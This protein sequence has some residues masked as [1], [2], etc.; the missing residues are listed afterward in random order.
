MLPVSA[1]QA[2]GAFFTKQDVSPTPPLPSRP[3]SGDK[4]QMFRAPRAALGLWRP[5]EIYL[6]FTRL[7]SDLKGIQQL[8]MIDACENPSPLADDRHDN[9]RAVTTSTTTALAPAAERGALATEGGWRL[10]VATSFAAIAVSAAVAVAV[11]TARTT[12]RNSK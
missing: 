12:R 2:K 6:P 5:N 7:W 4:R 9:L 10:A 11:T 8:C 3:R 1:P